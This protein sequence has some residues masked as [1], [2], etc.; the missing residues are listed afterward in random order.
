MNGWRKDEMK[1]WIYELK[2]RK[3]QFVMLVAGAVLLLIGFLVR[4]NFS[5]ILVAG[6][7]V[8]NSNEYILKL[9][10]FEQPV[11]SITY[12]DV[13]MVMLSILAVFWL[14]HTMSVIA[15]SIRR[16]RKMGTMEFFKTQG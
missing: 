6:I 5:G 14:Y 2:K 9:F 15:D 8:F 1:L 16:E 7:Q 12:T 4:R 10:G 11:T 3:S 13:M